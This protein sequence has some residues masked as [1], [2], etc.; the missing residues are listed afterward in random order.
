MSMLFSHSAVNSGRQIE[1]DVLKTV[2]IFEMIF[3]HLQ[4]VV[5]S[6][7]YGDRLFIQNSWGLLF[8]SNA[9]YLVGPFSFLFSMG[10]TIPFSRR[11]NASANM[12]RGVGLVVVWILLNALR[13]I[14][15]G[16]LLS[17]T[18]GTSFKE[19]YFTL[20][21]ANDVLFFTGVFFLLFGFLRMMK[22][23]VVK[24]ALFFAALFL[25]TQCVGDFGRFLPEATHRLF[26]GIFNIS[27]L[28]SF[29]LF[30]WGIVVMLGVGWGK[31]LQRTCN[32][33]ILY[34]ATEIVGFAAVAVLLGAL[35]FSGALNSETLQTS[36]SN[37]LGVH[38][39]G[40]V[41]LAGALAVLAFIL[42]LFY[43]LSLVLPE[44]V[45]KWI[46][47]VSGKILPIYFIHWLILPLLGFIPWMRT[48]RAGIGE[49]VFVALVLY[50]I[51]FFAVFFYECMK[52]KIFKD[53][54]TAVR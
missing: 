19:V 30:N 38:Q 28:S 48:G 25:V 13:L 24:I 14:P 41:S 4:E 32:K 36:A 42:P 43:F 3:S 23:S 1:L 21:L 31:L 5:F 10:C 15:Y 46:S 17:S 49:I 7:A 54:G 26:S 2:T 16:L 37:P 12:R 8:V 45:K 39:L 34:A 6:S 53:K 52:K 33:T 27:H 9:F 47:A 18:T 11:D 40:I 50:A 44:A 51:S 29:A 22:L 35:Y 20:L